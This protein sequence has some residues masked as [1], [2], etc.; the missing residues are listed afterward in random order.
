MSPKCDLLL[1][2]GFSL[3]YRA[4]Y[5]YPP[6]LTTPE[7][8]PINA[9]YGFITMM[10]N[11]LKQF[12][13]THVG[14]CLDRKEPTYR[15]E[16]FPE[17]KANR[18]APDDDFLVQL[19]EFK[20]LLSSFDIPLLELAGYESDDL[21]GTLSNQFSNQGKLTYILSSDM[22]LLQLINA[23][24][25][26]VMSKK[27]VSNYVVY[28]THELTKN[29]NLT[30]DQFIDYKALKGD[31]S[32]NI[33]GVKGVGEKT[34][35]ALLGTHHT[36]DGIYDQLAYI[37]SASVRKK[38][39]INKEMAYLSKTLVTINQQVPIQVEW[40]DFLFQPDWSKVHD[41]FETYQFK[42]LISRLNDFSKEP[43]TASN[44]DSNRDVSVSPS[45]VIP[46]EPASFQVID[47]VADATALMPLLTHGFAF[48]LETTSLDPRDAHIVA[49]AITASKGISFVIY[50]SN[51]M[52]SGRLLNDE[53][54]LHPLMQV[55]K[56]VLEDASI[57]KIAHNAKYEYQVLSTV[58]IQL[59]GVSFDTMLAAH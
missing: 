12:N 41:L 17:Y 49:V 7:G 24:T 8:V 19:P 35:L 50:C 51:N 39:E 44:T 40:D 14:I 33:P 20:R 9:V 59:N 58:G 31:P 34:A 55:L 46:Y 29:F 52:F 18:S 2:D 37:S 13:P 11:A 6:N 26:I 4:Y 5:G 57:P 15:H 28:D 1:I 23:N 3:L 30:T 56:P 43:L 36:L 42:R 53:K 10:L 25:S 38:L 21:L 47:T 54:P 32:D 45:T 48:D 27:G 16:L 22:D